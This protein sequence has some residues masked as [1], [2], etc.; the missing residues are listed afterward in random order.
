[1]ARKLRAF[2]SM[3]GRDRR[4]DDGHVHFHRG[5]AG[6]PAVCDDPRCSMPR[7]DVE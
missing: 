1:M 5:P 2:I 7:L 4:L 3:L 6:Q